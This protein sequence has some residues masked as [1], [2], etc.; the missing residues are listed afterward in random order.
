M[1]SCASTHA[2]TEVDCLYPT[3]REE[4]GCMNENR[5]EARGQLEGLGSACHVPKQHKNLLSELQIQ[6]MRLKD[7]TIKY[8][9]T[10]VLCTNYPHMGYKEITNNENKRM[11]ATVRDRNYYTFHY[12]TLKQILY[13]NGNDQKIRELE[14]G[15]TERIYDHYN[16][17]GGSRRETNHMTKEMTARSIA[18]FE[19]IHC[20][21]GHYS[22]EHDCKMLDAGRIADCIYT[23]TDLRNYERIFGWCKACKA[24]QG[25]YI[26]KTKSTSQ[27]T[28][29]P[30][31]LTHL[32]WRIHGSNHSLAGVDDYSNMMYL[33]RVIGKNE[34]SHCKAMEKMMAQSAQFGHDWERVRTDRE[35]VFLQAQQS[36]NSKGIVAET[37]EIDAHEKKIERYIGIL[38]AKRK[39]RL[40]ELEMKGISPPINFKTHM[41]DLCCVQEMNYN[42]KTNEEGEEGRPP[43]EIFTGKKVSM[44]KHLKHTYGDMVWCN[45]PNRDKAKHNSNVEL[46]MCLYRIGEQGV[47][48]VYIFNK[49]RVY[50]RTPI[51]QHVEDRGIPNRF[52][53]TENINEA[54]RAKMEQ[55]QRNEIIETDLTQEGVISDKE[56]T[57]EYEQMGAI[58]TTA[59]D[60]TE[61]KMLWETRNKTRAE[62]ELDKDITRRNKRTDKINTSETNKREEEKRQATERREGDKTSA[63]NRIHGTRQSIK[64]ANEELKEDKQARRKKKNQEK[65]HSTTAGIEQTEETDRNM[66]LTW[67]GQNNKKGENT[68]MTHMTRAR[69]KVIH[70]EATGIAC[71]KELRTI[72][73]TQETFE[74]IDP[75][76]ITDWEWKHKVLHCF[77]MLT[78]KIN[79]DGKFEKVKARFNANP[80]TIREPLRQGDNASPTTSTEAVNA[81]LHSY[82]TRR[83]YGAVLRTYDITGAFLHAVFREGGY[84]G[85]ID[86]DSAEEVLAMRPDLKTGLRRDGTL[87]VRIVKALYGLE[88][89]AKLF[90][91][92][93]TKTIIAHGYTRTCADPCALSKGKAKIV[94]NKYNRE[95]D[96]VAIHV[97]DLICKF[98]SV[99]QAVEFEEILEE[100][101][102][103]ITK[104]KMEDG[105]I[106][107]TGRTI[108]LN[109]DY[110]LEISMG[111]ITKKILQ[112]HKGLGRRS[113]P[114]SKDIFKIS[115]EPKDMVKIDPVPFLSKIM[116][117]MYLGKNMRYDIMLPL[118]FLC[119][120]VR[121]PTV[122]DD[123]KLNHIL[124]YVKRTQEEVLLY[125][126]YTN[127][128]L[129]IYAD[130]A[131]NCH[132]DGKGHSGIVIKLGCNTIGIRCNKQKVSTQSSCEAEILSL[133][134]ATCDAEWIRDMVE[135]MGMIQEGPTIIYED[136]KSAMTLIGRGFSI[137][138]RY[139]ARRYLYIHEQQ[140]NN[141]IR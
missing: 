138:N 2:I 54:Q 41:L 129:T 127:D 15:G 76:D 97:D 49:M 140:E 87:L 27:P 67:T 112:G 130:A 118:S 66:I 12:L 56:A 68:E 141:K 72:A 53:V 14:D 89:A 19:K 39:M 117:G 99:N 137:S 18:A 122:E 88:E 82:V 135:E 64:K 38:N 98:E 28:T 131:Y 35:H 26:T 119:T 40:T 23:S 114:A 57:Q 29:K 84:I 62:K 21:K 77:M 42:G 123:R 94:I 73:V 93:L 126:Q 32:D 91:K 17:R 3:T 79:S 6:D 22:L 107:F 43:Y 110:D 106:N 20:K 90:Y 46:G 86:K 81:I 55:I 128:N 36:L 47:W 95:K 132:Q 102:G 37:T 48:G 7:K 104:H 124:D 92:M 125:K 85:I 34:Q 44:K 60:R 139:L 11:V 69:M 52:R 13:L 100:T 116:T 50:A 51:R 8:T 121:E 75:E 71:K 61:D 136:N 74:P 105:S 83:R 59:E 10:E 1:D 9:I 65:Q 24:G 133:Q 4:H 96:I 101:Y 25:H 113:C 70:P 16:T 45:R 33:S 115:N 63:T 108:R 5:I 58:S 111:K 30:G 120:R 31:E 109:K 103:E 78:E 134:F 80:T